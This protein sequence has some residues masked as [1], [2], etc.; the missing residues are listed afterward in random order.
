MLERAEAVDEAVGNA[1]C[2]QQHTT[3]A[4]RKTDVLALRVPMM[5]RKLAEKAAAVARQDPAG[6]A[7]LMRLD[8]N[9]VTLQE[10][11]EA[12]ENAA[13]Q[14]CQW[15]SFN[16]LKRGYA[17]SMKAG[18]QNKTQ[19]QHDD[20]FEER[21][22]LSALDASYHHSSSSRHQHHNRR[23]PL[24]ALARPPG[25]VSLA[26]KYATLLEDAFK[27][28]QTSLAA[29]DVLRARLPTKPSLV[30]FGSASVCP[31]I[32]E[33]PQVPTTP[34]S[35]WDDEALATAKYAAEDVDDFLTDAAPLGMGIFCSEVFAC[36][37]PHDGALFLT[38][39]WRTADA[40]GQKAVLATTTI[41][42]VL[43]DPRK[44][45]LD[46]GDQIWAVTI[47]GHDYFFCVMADNSDRGLRHA[48][49]VAGADDALLTRL[50]VAFR[51]VE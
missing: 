41:Y 42:K 26:A 7:N 34:A 50:G 17:R 22:S 24:A 2:D 21:G 25:N 48:C 27:R 45:A 44:M 18:Q 29:L 43:D 6:L 35:P 14:A 28:I 19:Q 12:L 36:R 30:R 38:S 4:S 49:H 20:A 51:R 10:A 31:A 3:A 16:P 32:L 8:P 40:V 46:D 1:S 37:D 9:E 47:D 33:E 11:F 13:T 5:L 15:L 39:N 23:F